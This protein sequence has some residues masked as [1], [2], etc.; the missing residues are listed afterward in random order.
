MADKLTFSQCLY[1]F[2]SGDKK[3]AE[4]NVIRPKSIRQSNCIC[5]RKSG[6]QEAAAVGSLPPV[7]AH[8]H[9]N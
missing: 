6:N 3:G 1:A 7:T 9:L 4:K 8:C 2:F 5:D